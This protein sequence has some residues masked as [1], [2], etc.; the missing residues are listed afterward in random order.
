MLT[1]PEIVE[2]LRTRNLAKVAEASGMKYLTLYKLVKEQPKG[3]KY[4][5]V[6]QISDY[7]ERNL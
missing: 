4:E 1:V 7:L 5:T 3:V 6:K 2:R